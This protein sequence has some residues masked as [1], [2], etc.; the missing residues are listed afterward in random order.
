MLHLVYFISALLHLELVGN[1]AADFLLLC[2]KFE[3][4]TFSHSVNIKGKTPNVWELP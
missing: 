1:L 3:V 2:A 4:D